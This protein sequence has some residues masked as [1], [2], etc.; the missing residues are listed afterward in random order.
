MELVSVKFSYVQNT[1]STGEALT[2]PSTGNTLESDGFSHLREET[3]WKDSTGLRWE[4]RWRERLVRASLGKDSVFVLLSISTILIY[5]SLLCKCVEGQ[6]HKQQLLLKL[7]LLK[8]AVRE[9]LK[10][11]SVFSE[12]PVA[13]SPFWGKIQSL[14]RGKKKLFFMIYTVKYAYVSIAC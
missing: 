7:R 12:L 2:R 3:I 10:A 9:L 1:S 5:E 13:H 14:A 8:L 4:K 6:T 11:H